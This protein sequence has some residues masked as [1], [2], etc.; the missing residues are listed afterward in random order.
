MSYLPITYTFEMFDLILKYKRLQCSR[1]KISIKKYNCLQCSRTNMN[2]K[3]KSSVFYIMLPHVNMCLHMSTCGMSQLPGC[4]RLAEGTSGVSSPTV[5]K[6]ATKV[7]SSRSA[8]R[9][10]KVATKVM[11]SRSAPRVCQV[12]AKDT[13][14]GFHNHANSDI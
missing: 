12:A 2:F 6:V 4:S 7:M 14:I 13:V 3:S 9:V 10:C 5:C 1:T 8:P 11:S